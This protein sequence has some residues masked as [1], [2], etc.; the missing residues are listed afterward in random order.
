MLSD[1]LTQRENRLREKNVPN[2]NSSRS[3]SRREKRLRKTFYVYKNT[4]K[5]F[6][7]FLLSVEALLEA[8][9]K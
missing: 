5:F 8:D 4:K 1:Q 7:M 9:N 3:S 2:Q 6:S